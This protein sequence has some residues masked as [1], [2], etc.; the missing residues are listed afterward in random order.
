MPYSI[1]TPKSGWENVDRILSGW[2]QTTRGRVRCRPFLWAAFLVVW[3]C[4]F[5]A[6][7]ALADSEDLLVARGIQKLDGR[8]FEGAL[9]LFT[10]ALAAAPD[11]AEANY[12]AGFTYIR[13]G[14]YAEAETCL[15]KALAA[16]PDNAAVV[17]ELGSV[18]SLTGDCEKAGT[19]FAKLKDPFPGRRD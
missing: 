5:P 13:L 3:L 14:R 9:Q 6:G 18:Y 19:T 12:Y 2:R 16:D 7:S 10:Q 15:E 1:D 17:F 11:G 8:D 4:G